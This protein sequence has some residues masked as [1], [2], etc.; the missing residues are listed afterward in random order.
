MGRKLVWSATGKPVAAVLA[1]QWNLMPQMRALW[2]AV[3]P[4]SIARRW[5]QACLR[6]AIEC[7]VAAVP[8]HTAIPVRIGPVRIGPVRMGLHRRFR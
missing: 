6:A 2:D 5:Q 3:E 1:E 8:T 7:G 4:H